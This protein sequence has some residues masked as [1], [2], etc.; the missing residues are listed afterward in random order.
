MAQYLNGFGVV[1]LPEELV[2]GLCIAQRNLRDLFAKRH[3]GLLT[4]GY[5]LGMQRAL[6]KGWVPRVTV[7]PAKARI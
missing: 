6:N 5:W 2:S 7:Y 4:T 1:F 3:A